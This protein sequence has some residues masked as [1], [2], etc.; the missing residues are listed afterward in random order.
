MAH[1]PTSGNTL[2]IGQ[3]FKSSGT[4]VY[5]HILLWL[6]LSVVLHFISWKFV[7]EMG[8]S[9]LK[10]IEYIFALQIEMIVKGYLKEILEKLEELGIFYIISE[11]KNKV[12]FV[13]DLVKSSVIALGHFALLQVIA[14][15]LIYDHVCCKK[16]T[17]IG[18]ILQR[19]KT[20]DFF[21][22]ILRT[23]GITAIYDGILFAWFVLHVVLG[24]VLLEVLRN[25]SSYTTVILGLVIYIIIFLF[26]FL[27]STLRLSLAVPLIVIENKKILESLQSSWHM[28]ASC[29]I[30]M[31]IVFVLTFFVIFVLPAVAVLFGSDLS[32]LLEPLFQLDSDLSQ[33]VV[34]WIW[35]IFASSVYAILMSVCYCYLWI[36][37]NRDNNPPK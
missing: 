37:K 2:P 32:V 13:V 15:R 24:N 31:P 28:T 16:E 3:V 12:D 11:K 1:D 9:L 21:F 26:C 17:S 18:S 27:S 22:H 20:T 34:H 14:S 36:A 8:S 10:Y 30:K 7:T 33:K 6:V 23:I 25:F 35:V 4:L 29:W 5:K 19:I